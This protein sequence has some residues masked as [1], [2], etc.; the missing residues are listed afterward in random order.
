[1]EPAHMA[2]LG[3]LIARALQGAPE[4]VAADVTFFR[5]RFSGLRCVRG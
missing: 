2:E 3:T 1:M 4:D 5:R